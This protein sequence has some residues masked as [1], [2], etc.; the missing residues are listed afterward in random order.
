MNQAIEEYDDIGVKHLD[1]LNWLFAH[2]FFVFFNIED[3]IWFEVVIEEE[4]EMA[5]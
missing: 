5:I 2:S 4:S 1:D 3:L